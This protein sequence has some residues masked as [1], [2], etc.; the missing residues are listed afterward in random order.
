[1]MRSAKAL[2][3]PGTRLDD[4]L[5]LG[6]DALQFGQI[7]PGD[8][9]ADGRLD[10][11]GEHVDAR[12]DRHGPGVVQAG[13]LHG[14]VH[15]VGQF[16]RRAAAMRDDFAVVVL[17]VHRRPFLLRLEHDGGFDH[18]QRRGIGG[19][20]G[21]AD[22]AEDVLHFGKRFDDLVGDLE[23]FA[24]LGGRDAGKGRRHVEQIA[25]VERRHEFRADVLIREKL[26]DLEGAM[27][28]RRAIGQHARRPAS[29]TGR[30]PRRRSAA[31]AMTTGQR[32]LM[33][34]SMTG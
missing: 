18:V 13:D 1:M 10:A 3:V 6:G 22:F 4:R 14:G 24:R 7:R 34:K 8:L 20:F 19:G 12:L 31:A 28:L 15:R 26:A 33:T 27:S 29:S 9:D 17:D 30:K 32:H 11:G 2:S 25:F 23:D 5:D 21:A 16:V